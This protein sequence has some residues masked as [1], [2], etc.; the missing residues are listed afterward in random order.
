MAKH[1]GIVRHSFT[2]MGQGILVEMAVLGTSPQPVPPCRIRIKLD[3]R[4]PCWCPLRPCFL[5]K[6]PHSFHGHISGLCDR[7]SAKPCSH[8]EKGLRTLFSTVCAQIHGY[9][10]KAGH[11][12]KTSRLAGLLFVVCFCTRSFFKSGLGLVYQTDSLEMSSRPDL[13]Y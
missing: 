9:T 13:S 4:N 1:R 10:E 11:E 8:P 6:G 3:E 7:T 5:R 2:N 12:P